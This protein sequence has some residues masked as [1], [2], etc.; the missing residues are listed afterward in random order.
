[1]V[2]KKK[3]ETADI[4]IEEFFVLKPNM[5]SY[6]EDDNS[7]YKKVTSI[8]KNVVATISHNK[9]KNVLLN[10][11]CLTPSMNRIQSKDHRIRTCGINKISLPCFDNQICIKK[12][13]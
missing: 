12:W 7:Y 5:H 13:M 9:Y 1:M 6:L 8:K 3:D 2:T 11:K 10:K 4:A